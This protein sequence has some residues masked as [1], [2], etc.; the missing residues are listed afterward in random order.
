VLINVS[1]SNI[2]RILII[3]SPFIKKTESS[4][5]NPYTIVFVCAFAAK[6][7]ADADKDTIFMAGGLPNPS[8]FPFESLTVSLGDEK[9]LTLKDGALKAA[10][11]YQPTLG[12]PPLQET[13]KKVVRELWKPPHMDKREIIVTAGSQNGLAAVLDLVVSEGDA[14]VVPVPVY[15]SVVAVVSFILLV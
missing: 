14:V 2:V 4:L 6:K 9:T 12:Y 13:L 8:L 5:S 10:L 15:P 1:N 3:V 7:L 11:Q